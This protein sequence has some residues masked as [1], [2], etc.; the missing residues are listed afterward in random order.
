MDEMLRGFA[1]VV[2]MG[3]TKV[4]FDNTIAIHTIS[5]EELEA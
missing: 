1:V 3:A 4:D 2:N 5:A